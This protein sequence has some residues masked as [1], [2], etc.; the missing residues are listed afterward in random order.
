VLDGVRTVSIGE[1]YPR[2]AMASNGTLAY[3]PGSRLG[4]GRRLAVVGSNG[5][6][7]L[8]S[9]D[10]RPLVG[11][12]SIAANG[13][14]AVTAMTPDGLLFEIW[15]AEPGESLLRRVVSTPGVDNAD[16]VLSRDGTRFAFSRLGR[17]PDD[18]LYVREVDGGTERRLAEIRPETRWTP[19]DWWPD[20][21]LLLAERLAGGNA[22]V[23]LLEVDGPPGAEPRP[24]LAASGV[25]ESQARVSPDGRTLAFVTDET[26]KPEVYVAPLGPDGLVGA[27]LRVSDG[28]G[29]AVRWRP[30]GRALLFWDGQ[31]QIFSV[32][33][34]ASQRI[35]VG[36][37]EPLLRLQSAGLT[38]GFDVMPDGRLLFVA[39]GEEEGEAE[40]IDVVIGFGAE[41]AASG[42]ER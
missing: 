36:R 11:T 7:A 28:S 5:A 18:G 3:V 31:D 16:P 8:W 24:L 35:V 17:T 9:E 6:P 15:L 32:P 13:R 14:I 27:P 12:P 30:D 20:G 42:A 10:R 34:Q 22:D 26:G 4:S 2:F 38:R 25:D 1:P 40:R 37:P 39:Q 33:V 41:L 23:V 21:R 19:L 29:S